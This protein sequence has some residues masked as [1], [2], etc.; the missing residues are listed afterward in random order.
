MEVLQL[1]A[2]FERQSLTLS[3]SFVPRRR[4]LYGVDFTVQS[5]PYISHLV[6]LQHGSSSSLL[7]YTDDGALRVHDKS[8][9]DTQILLTWPNGAGCTSFAPV[10]GGFLAAGRS[11]QVGYWDLRQ[12]VANS[13]SPTTSLA[14]PSRAPY[15]AVASSGTTIAA[16]TELHGSDATIDIWW[17]LPTSRLSSCD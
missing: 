2:T 10:E 6:S 4:P 7:S 17:V 12:P 1:G 8:T 13:E 3:N 9:L 15:L 14:G 11:G 5:S 16:G